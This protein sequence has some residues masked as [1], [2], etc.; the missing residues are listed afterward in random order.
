M[1]GDFGVYEQNYEIDSYKS[2]GLRQLDWKQPKHYLFRASF[3]KVRG[4]I[5]KS[6]WNKSLL[7]IL[8]F[9]GRIWRKVHCKFQV[10]RSSVWNQYTQSASEQFSAMLEAE[11]EEVPATKI[12]ETYQVYNFYFGRFQCTVENFWDKY[13]ARI[14]FRNI[15][16]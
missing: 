5:S 12:M 1:L 15:Q 6:A 10:Q 13:T 11:F 16:L 14:R 9:I 3:E 2:A 8:K 7:D 4:Q